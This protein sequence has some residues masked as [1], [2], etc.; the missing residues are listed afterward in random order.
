M[1]TIKHNGC[2]WIIPGLTDDD[3][4][5]LADNDA[6]APD[7]ITDGTAWWYDQPDAQ[8]CAGIL[9]D[10]ERVTW[11]PCAS[12]GEPVDPDGEPTDDDGVCAACNEAADDRREDERA[13]ARD[14][15][16]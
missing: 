4:I 9:N 1:Y 13:W 5:L 2:G 8:E 12:C 3:L 11:E 6:P 16:C 14:R 7:G 15:G 10:L